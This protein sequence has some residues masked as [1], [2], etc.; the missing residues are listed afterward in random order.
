MFL[1]GGLERWG[2]PAHLPLHRHRVIGRR[3]GKEFHTTLL[4]HRSEGGGWYDEDSEGNRPSCASRWWRDHDCPAESPQGIRRHRRGASRNDGPSR[5]RP[6]RSFLAPHFCSRAC[7]CGQP[8]SAE[9][10]DSWD[11]L[12]GESANTRKREAMRD[13][14]VIGCDTRSGS[15]RARLTTTPPTS[16]AETTDEGIAIRP[17]QTAADGY[18]TD[19]PTSPNGQP[20][21]DHIV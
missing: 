11:R 13:G 1:G 21:Q 8:R 10:R 5:I 19:G 6:F 18:C 14:P 15:A 7:S 2:A 4:G 3:A 20:H 17:F 9:L 12:V 16:T